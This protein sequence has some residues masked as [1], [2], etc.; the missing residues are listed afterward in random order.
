ML[1]PVLLLRISLLPRMTLVLPCSKQSL[2]PMPRRR[3][4][5]AAATPAPIA[6]VIQTALDSG[7]S[8]NQAAIIATA[9]ESGASQV[10]ILSAALAAGVSP[11]DA[12]VI[13]SAVVSSNGSG[14]G[15]SPEQAAVLA[16]AIQT[17]ATEAEIADII[18]N[19]GVGSLKADIIASTL[20]ALSPGS[21]T[22]IEK[23][24]EPEKIISNSEDAGIPPGVAAEIAVA[25][26][27]GETKQQI[28]QLGVDAG[29]SA[30][31]VSNIFAGI[32]T[33][34]HKSEPEPATDDNTLPAYHFTPAPTAVGTE[35]DTPS[36]TG[37]VFQNIVA[38]LT[39]APAKPS[40]RSRPQCAPTA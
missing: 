16:V 12:I 22:N 7:A 17:G 33:G 13:A 10:G 21:A 30:Q 18:K 40:L 15:A 19:N 37:G 14:T 32:S 29:I 24:D 25:A 28:E 23:V 4:S 39:S 3:V 26:G 27:Q 20:S 1:L 34:S 2:W 5:R 31:I 38:Y 9:V 11:K 35:V 36:T 8:L 6:V